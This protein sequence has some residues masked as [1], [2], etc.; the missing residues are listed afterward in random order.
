MMADYP[1]KCFCNNWKLELFL[2]I[3]SKKYF[4]QQHD[5]WKLHF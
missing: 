4:F 5:I 3:E 1:E 2:K